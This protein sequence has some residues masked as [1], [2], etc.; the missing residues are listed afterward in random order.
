[1]KISEFLKYIELQLECMCNMC[2]WVCK[3]YPL[4][5]IC[6]KIESKRHL[7]ISFIINFGYAILSP[8]TPDDT[9]RL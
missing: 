3:M 9:G 2:F 8:D 1:M 5:F 6:N 7:L 4:L